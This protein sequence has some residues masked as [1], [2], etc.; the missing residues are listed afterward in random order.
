MTPVSF[1]RLRHWPGLA[2]VATS[3]F[4]GAMA[5]TPLP[6]DR[7]VRWGILATGGIAATVTADLLALPDECEVVAVASRDLDHARAFAAERG[8]PRAYGSYQELAEDDGVD[9]VYVATPHSH[10]FEPAR[11][12]IEAGRHV[13]VEKPLTPSAA[14]TYALLRL[15]QEHDRVCM[16]AVWMRCNPIIRRAAEL[17]HDGA[18]GELSHVR[19]NFDITFTGDDSHRLVN[20]AL[21]GGAILDLGVYPLHAMDLILGKPDSLVAA[22]RLHRTGVEAHAEALLTWG[23]VV[24]HAS[25]S[26]GGQTP[27]ALHLVGS[28]GRIEVPDFLKPS[29]MTL[30]P[31]EGEPEEFRA[32]V[33]GNGYTFEAQEVNACLRR[34]AL[35][36][37]LVDHA[38]TR[39]VAAVMDDWRAQVGAPDLDSHEPG[40]DS[41]E[42]GLDSHEPALD[43]H[44]VE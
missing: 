2:P 33:P 9:V 44:E 32:R 25:C 15:A 11:A 40:L 21:A 27:M 28:T 16:E 3:R 39:R 22:G 13:L 26:I 12:C 30:V 8:I 35:E 37:S 10:H 14:D 41:H 29:R 38:S 17:V 4:D 1:V 43:S 23:D 34:G 5:P 36:S 20:P 19:A 24:G 31:R 42:P 6:Q 7:P 18:I